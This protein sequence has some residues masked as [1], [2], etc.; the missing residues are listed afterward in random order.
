MV[1]LASLALKALD[2][3]AWA[4]EKLD[5]VHRR[6]FGCV[7]VQGKDVGLAMAASGQ[8]GAASE[9]CLTLTVEWVEQE[10]WLSPLQSHDG[11]GHHG[12]ASVRGA[13]AKLACVR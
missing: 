13:G 12:P 3:R 6:L 2:R 1:G 10:G 7:R 11:Q 8:G 9:I 5:A 4:V